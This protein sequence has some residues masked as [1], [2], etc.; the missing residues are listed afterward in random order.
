MKVIYRASYVGSSMP[1]LDISP[2]QYLHLFTKLEALQTYSFEI[3]TEASSCRYDQLLTPFPALCPSL[4]NERY[5]VKIPSLLFLVTSLHLGVT[6]ESE[7]KT[8]LLP[9]K[10]PEI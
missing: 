5:G 10:S 9:S 2:S 6:Q 4:E 3:F 8:L 1:S 7:Q